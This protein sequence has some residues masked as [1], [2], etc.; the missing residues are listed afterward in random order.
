MKTLTEYAATTN[1]LSTGIEVHLPGFP[2]DLVVIG[3]IPYQSNIPEQAI[4]PEN[5]ELFHNYVKSGKYSFPISTGIARNAGSFAMTAAVTLY[6]WFTKDKQGIFVNPMRFKS[7]VDKTHAFRRYPDSF[8]VKST[9]EAEYIPSP[10]EYVFYRKDV[11]VAVARSFMC[12]C[13]Y[14]NPVTGKCETIIQFPEELV[15]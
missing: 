1:R 10:D 15:L 11:A 7:H 12:Q 2:V 13:R 4:V 3:F 6:S 5:Y 14:M 9:I 8:T